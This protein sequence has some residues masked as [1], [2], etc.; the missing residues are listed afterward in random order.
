MDKDTHFGDP[1][2]G[3]TFF[4]G[5]GGGEGGGGDSRVGKSVFLLISFLFLFCLFCW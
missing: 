2:E 3:D 4:V 1:G 5:F